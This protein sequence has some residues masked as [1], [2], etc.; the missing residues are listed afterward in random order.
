VFAADLAD[1]YQIDG[2]WREYAQTRQYF[3]NRRRVVGTSDGATPKPGHRSKSPFSRSH[4][5]RRQQ[6]ATDIFRPA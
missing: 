4:G 6:R 5:T 1:E 2:G 3:K